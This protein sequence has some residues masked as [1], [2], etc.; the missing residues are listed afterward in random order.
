MTPEFSAKINQLRAI[1]ALWVFVFHYEHFI[2]HTF[3]KPIERLNPIEVLMYNGYIGVSLF[4][5]LSGFLFAYVYRGYPQLNFKLYY[6]KRLLRIL[7][8]LIVLI[9]VYFC[10]FNTQ[11]QTFFKL[12]SIILYDNVTAYPQAIGHLWSIN[13]EFQCYALFPLLWTLAYRWGCKPLVAIGVLSLGALLTW[14]FRTHPALPSF[15]GSFGL[16]FCEFL[17]GMLA[18]LVFKPLAVKRSVLLLLIIG[19]T[20]LLIAVHMLSWQ[21][22]LAFSALNIVGLCINSCF[23]MLFIVLYLQCLPILPA[24]LTKTLE[25][26]GEVSYSFYLYHFLVIVFFVKHQ[27]LLSG[28]PVVRFSLLLGIS[29][30]VAFIAY[31]LI[32]RPALNLKSRSFKSLMQGK[33]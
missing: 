26:I 32:E 9:V 29:L 20:A 8:S 15:Y 33:V 11:Q 31:Q 25:K 5:C 4:F 30:G 24:L 7:P 19:Y 27:S 6:A 21:A 14:A 13:R 17:I 3:F 16:R 10:C 28:V 23:C 18:G 1:A 2:A 22:P 12:I